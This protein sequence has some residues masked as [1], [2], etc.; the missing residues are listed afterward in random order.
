MLHGLVAAVGHAC[1][2]PTRAPA[3]G[4]GACSCTG[5]ASAGPVPVPVGRVH[6]PCTYWRRWALPL[7][8]G[9]LPP[10]PPLPTPKPHSRAAL[11]PS[12]TQPRP[13]SAQ[14]PL[15]PPRLFRPALVPAWSSPGPGRREFDP[16]RPSASPDRPGPAPPP[17]DPALA[18]PAQPR[19]NA[20]PT[21]PPQSL[22]PSALAPHYPPGPPPLTPPAA[23]APESP[24][25][26]KQGRSVPCPGRPRRRR[27]GSVQ[28]AFSPPRCDAVRERRAAR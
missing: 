28:G 6:A 3:G 7:P 19:P 21:P 22:S 10:P 24:R 26:P 27:R 18:D 23:Q 12:P 9:G 2:G 1:L 8:G 17:T 16:A 20:A 11:G 4:A 14:S 25:A 15:R 13:G 5:D